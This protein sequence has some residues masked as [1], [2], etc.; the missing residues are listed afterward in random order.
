LTDQV[1]LV[2]NVTPQQSGKLTRLDLAQWIV[3]A[4][5]P[6]T[7]RVTVNWVWHKY[8]GRGIVPTLAD[9]RTQGEKRKDRRSS[10]LAALSVSGISLSP[11]CRLLIQPDRDGGA[12]LAPPRASDWRVGRKWRCLLF[13]VIQGPGCYATLIPWETS[14]PCTLQR[15]FRPRRGW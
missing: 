9:F 4:K 3:D 6:L 2:L 7:A 13:F 5:N 8:F 10:L 14:G 1:P 11:Q 15:K 12:S